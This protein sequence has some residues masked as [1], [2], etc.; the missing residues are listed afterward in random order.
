MDHGELR[1]PQVF[2]KTA[3]RNDRGMISVQPGV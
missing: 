3:Q 2:Q 1:A